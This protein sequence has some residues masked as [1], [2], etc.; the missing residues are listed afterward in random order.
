MAPVEKASMLSLAKRYLAH[1]RKMG[2]ALAIEGDLLLDFARFADG[3][4]PRPALTTS[5][6]LRWA[7]RP[8]TAS[9]TYHAV[10]Y[11]VVRGFARYC[12]ALDPRTDNTE[13]PPPHRL[14]FRK[15]GHDQLEPR[16]LLPLILSDSQP[17]INARS[18]HR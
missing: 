12:A 7:T 14:D 5:L 9:R 6:V 1:R 8:Q 11:A 17:R 16:Q 13:N 4:A 15:L 3:I 2:F 18:L 10:R